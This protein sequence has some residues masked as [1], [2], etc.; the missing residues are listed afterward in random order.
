MKL[1]NDYVSRELYRNF[2]VLGIL[3]KHIHDKDHLT[4]ETIMNQLGIGSRS[5]LRDSIYFLKNTLNV[6]I[7]CCGGTYGGVWIDKDWIIR[8]ARLSQSEVKLLIRLLVKCEDEEDYD[9]LIGIV[10]RNIDIENDFE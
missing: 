10:I 5:T 4:Y 1:Y 6:P 2:A 8:G 7:R 9:I 3:I